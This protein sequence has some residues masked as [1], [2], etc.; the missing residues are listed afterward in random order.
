MSDPVQEQLIT[1]RKNQILD[2]AA[3]VFAEK[4]FHPTT[5]KDIAR[6][7]GIADGTIYNYFKNKTALI[8]GIFDRMRQTIQQDIPPVQPG[9]LDLRTF[10]QTF[11]AHPLIAFRTDNFGLFRV[12]MSE[13]MVNEELRKLYQEEILEPT[14]MLA[15]QTLQALVEQG[16]MKDVNVPLTVRTITG[17]VMG[18]MLQYLVG[19]ELVQAQVEDLPEAMTVLILDGLEKSS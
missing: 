19:D 7:A 3:T 9:D 17:M 16:R 5:I 2:A 12:I 14:I 10:V 4:G 15:E 6:E 11:L 13:M 1:A 8:L 18:L